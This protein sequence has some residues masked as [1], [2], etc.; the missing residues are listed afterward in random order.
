[1][2][3]KKLGCTDVPMRTY[4]RAIYCHTQLGQLEEATMIYKKSRR[5]LHHKMPML[6]D[7]AYIII[8]LAL[9]GNFVRA[10][11]IL[12]KQLPY[13]LAFDCEFHVQEFYIGV[14]FFLKILELEGQTEIKLPAS[15]QLPVENKKGAFLI[16]DLISFFEK[17]IER[18]AQL[19]NES[20]L[21]YTSPS[22]RDRTRSR[23]PSSA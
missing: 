8:F 17:E 11:N 16:K 2:I 13:A 3:Q 23:M 6:E 20:C 18:I 4:G 22:P 21:L 15:I 1:M 10:K 9:T 14:L 5:A 7:Y 19:F 12:K